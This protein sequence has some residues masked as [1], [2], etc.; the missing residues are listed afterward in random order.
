MWV[1]YPWNG[2]ANEQVVT[3]NY[4]FLQIYLYSTSN[5]CSLLSKTPD[6]TMSQIESSFDGNLCRCTGYRPI[7]DAFKTFAIDADPALLDKVPDIEECDKVTKTQNSLSAKKLI[8]KAF[9]AKI[10]PKTREP[11]TGKCSSKGI[12][13]KIKTTDGEWYMPTTLEDLLGVLTQLPKG[14]NY[15]LVAGNITGFGNP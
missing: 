11:C 14:T 6:P 3:A 13:G 8:L 7:M 12:V 1:L 5:F 4:T 10:C 15:K 2:D 9:Q